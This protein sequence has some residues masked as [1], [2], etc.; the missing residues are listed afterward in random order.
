MGKSD[1]VKAT[2]LS[3]QSQ[4]RS[5]KVG[6][7]PREPGKNTFPGESLR[8]QNKS[9]LRARTGQNITK[10]TRGHT[11]FAFPTRTAS[12]TV[13]VIQKISY[14]SLLFHFPKIFL[15]F[16]ILALPCIC[17][18]LVLTI[19]FPQIW[20]RQRA[21]ASLSLV[22]EVCACD[23]SFSDEIEVAMLELTLRG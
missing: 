11:K 14:L 10:S 9:S 19:L 1:E 6:W 22:I 15:V 21:E 12:S 13:S 16:I 8:F 2:I 20:K 23:S 17:F 7:H 4:K 3:I 18:L 5:P